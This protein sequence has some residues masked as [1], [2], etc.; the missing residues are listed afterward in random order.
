MNSVPIIFRLVSGS[1]TPASAVKKRSLAST[2]FSFTPVEATK[3]RSTCSASPSRSKPWSTN[4]QV[5]CE[6]TAFCTIAA[7]TA[8]STPPDRPQRTRPVPTSFFIFST[9]V[10]TIFSEFQVGLHPTTSINQRR[11]I[12]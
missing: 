1:V 5:S 12:S 3:S 7:A 8:E 11:K 4:T 9:S 10:L 6:P 2:T